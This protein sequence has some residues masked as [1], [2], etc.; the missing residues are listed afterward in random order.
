MVHFSL[1]CKA[2]WVSKIALHVLLLCH[3][4]EE[5]A[6][7]PTDP[8][9]STSELRGTAAA[10][11]QP[12][13]GGH[14]VTQARAAFPPLCDAGGNSRVRH[15][16]IILFKTLTVVG[17]AACHL[18]AGDGGAALHLG[19]KFAENRQHVEIVTPLTLHLYSKLPPSL[20]PLSY[21]TTFTCTFILSYHLYL[22]LYPKLPPLYAPLS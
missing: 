13:K 3:P 5:G 8:H 12:D 22:H 4:S 16:A 14:F 15:T 19:S 10:A 9:T 7:E 20:P 1:S 6:K 21:T 17:G 11:V 18:L 2:L